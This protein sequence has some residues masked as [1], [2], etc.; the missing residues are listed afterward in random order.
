MKDRGFVL[1]NA[2]VLVA[3]MAVLAVFLMYLSERAQ[4]R[5]WAAQEY[6]QAVLYLDGAEALV[7]TRLQRDLQQNSTDTAD[8]DWAKP[9]I[10]TPID[11][12]TI[13]VTVVD[14]Q[15]RFN[16]NW[17]GNPEDDA[18]HAVFDRYA[19]SIGLP[20]T[21]AQNIAAF[22]KPGIGYGQIA[23]MDELLRVESMTPQRL[24]RYS[25][26]LTALPADTTLNINAADAD[27]LSAFF[28]GL[29]RTTLDRIMGAEPLVSAEA[30]VNAVQTALGEDARD[31]IDELRF[32]VGSAWYGAE[33]YARL[34]A[35]HLRRQSVLLRRPPP[36]G[37]TV[38]HR[39]TTRD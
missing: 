33:I 38:V 3:A 36:T 37:T 13:S 5:R 1:V 4:S 34:G 2:L 29:S 26:H 9:V 21:L 31:D 30:F 20:P 19:E 8:E 28:P 15:G 7:A 32:S 14:L 22:V 16:V 27:L 24:L 6:A 10:N 12:G 11:R 23:M 39:V 35:V 17:L 18:I 25:E